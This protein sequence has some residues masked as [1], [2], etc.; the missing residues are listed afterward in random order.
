MAVEIT[1]I[2]EGGLRCL[3]THVPSESQLSTDAPVDNGGQ[4]AAFSP[5]DLVA[6]ALGTCIMTTMGLVAA[7]HDIDLT[8]T[9][10]RVLKVM[11]AQPPR[12]IASLATDVIVPA[13]AV[14]DE[15]HRSRLEAAANHCP[16]HASL[17]PEIEAPIRFSYE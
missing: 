14:S 8:G 10:V 5:T 12:R 11:T 15:K 1:A 6:T 16:V 7:R 9:R 4:G 13:D 3:A 17:H 2:Y